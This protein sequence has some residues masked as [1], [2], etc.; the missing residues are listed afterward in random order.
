MSNINANIGRNVIVLFFGLAW[1]SALYWRWGLEAHGTEP[2]RRIIILW[3]V[4]RSGSSTLAR[5]FGQ[6]ND[7]EMFFEPFS[8]VH[9]LGS[10]RESERHSDI[11]PDREQT[12][13]KLW[14]RL[15]DS[16]GDRGVAFAKDF[17]SSV[18]RW[19]WDALP[20]AHADHAFLIRHP[21]E[22]LA[23]MYSIVAM[24]NGTGY[25]YVDPEEIGYEGQ[26]EM[27]NYVTKHLRKKPVV[28]DHADLMRDPES[29]LRT[30][31][32][33]LDLAF[34]PA[35]LTFTKP[36]PPHAHGL[37][38]GFF[39][40]VNAS[41]GFHTVSNKT[42]GPRLHQLPD[43]AQADVDRLTTFFHT[44]THTPC[45]LSHTHSFPESSPRDHQYRF[46]CTRA[47]ISVIALSLTNVVRML[48]DE[49]AGMMQRGCKSGCDDD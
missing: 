25:T 26:F 15:S 16:C 27:F 42:R 32:L 45:F 6:R 40:K 48:Y 20:L 7:V 22:A 11:P 14:S 44:Q 47:G 18:P 39:T 5:S 37:W 38:D 23:S 8:V 12:F 41:K 24:E 9:F 29:A 10:D 1:Y 21:Q 31:C 2:E 35:M 33:A 43:Q 17:V 46:T 19:R 34:D 30:F 3:A 28:L 13:G 36:L 49:C 4:Y